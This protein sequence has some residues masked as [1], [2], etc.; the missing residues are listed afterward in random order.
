MHMDF[1]RSNQKF[2]FIGFCLD[3]VEDR[4]NCV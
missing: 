4:F 1:G 3:D 2:G